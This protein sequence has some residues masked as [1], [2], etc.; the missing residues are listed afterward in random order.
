L[1]DFERTGPKPEGTLT[2][3][4]PAGF[5]ALDQVVGTEDGA[6]RGTRDTP[7]PLKAPVSAP[8][9][10]TAAFDASTFD[11]AASP[12]DDEVPIHF[13]CVDVKL[14]IKF[15]ELLNA[16]SPDTTLQ[17]VPKRCSGESAQKIHN[18]EM[19]CGF[20]NGAPLDCLEGHNRLA[21]QYGC[22]M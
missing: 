5:L 15:W 8:E 9:T 22:R 4:S 11:A 18:W 20:A 6:I 21:R 10:S 16:T 3:Q 12:H 2:P 19:Y 13:L 1:T 17:V 7:L 14:E